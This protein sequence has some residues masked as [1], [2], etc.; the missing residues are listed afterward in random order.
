[1]MD[2]TSINNEL[3]NL[4]YLQFGLKKPPQFMAASTALVALFQPNYFFDADSVMTYGVNSMATVFAMLGI[5]GMDAAQT[6][7][8]LV[9]LGTLPSGDTSAWA[10]RGDYLY[11][12]GLTL[13]VIVD[14]NNAAVLTSYGVDLSAMNAAPNIDKIARLGQI[15]LTKRTNDP[16]NF[17]FLE[18]SLSLRH[19]LDNL[20]SFDAIRV[21]YQATLTA[22][23]APTMV[24]SVNASGK[25]TFA[26]F[27]INSFGATIPVGTM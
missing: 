3:V 16:Q 15:L 7:V 18:N 20:A 22:V 1:M 24:T 19:F 13:A 4:F 26:T 8:S 21:G 23:T 6:L 27:G 17:G 9:S 5:T 25:S 11:F 10:K 12:L 2:A 14:P